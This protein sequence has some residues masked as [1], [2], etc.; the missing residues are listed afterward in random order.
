MK[1][2]RKL[3]LTAALA[4]LALAIAPA[5]AAR[6]T[7]LDEEIPARGIFSL[8]PA[9]RWEEGLLIGNGKMGGVVIGKPND[10]TIHLTHERVVVPEH[11]GEPP[12]KMAHILP[13]LRRMIRTGEGN[14]EKLMWETSR[15]ITGSGGMAWTDPFVN[16]GN[17][18]VEL[19]DGCEAKRYRRSLDYKTGMARVQWG[20]DDTKYEER[21][22]ISRADNVMV[23]Q[24][25]ATGK[26]PLTGRIR[27]SPGYF[28]GGDGASIV[29][30]DGWLTLRYNYGLTDGGYEIVGRVET[31]G[32]S[33]GNDDAIN[34]IDAK[35]V[36][37]LLRVVPLEN[38]GKSQ[39]DS[40]KKE[41]EKIAGSSF[42]QLAKRNIAKHGELFRRVELD[43]GGDPDERAMP[44]EELWAATHA[45]E[46][47]PA[48]L[49]RVFDAGRYEVICSTGDWPPNL[50]GVWHGGGKS[51]WQSDFTFNGNVPSAVA[52]YFNGNMPE[53]ML[54]LT[55]YMEERRPHFRANAEN[56]YDC[57]GLMVPG[58]LHIDGYAQHYSARYP[59]Q[60]WVSGAP[61][62][63]TFFY[64]YYRY[65]GDRDYLK[66][67]VVPWLKETAL[68]FEDYMVEN[69][70]GKYDIIPGY[71]PEHGGMAMNTT[72]DVA[73]V[74]ITLRNLISACRELGIEKDNIPKWQAMLDKMPDYRINKNGQLAEWID[75]RMRDNLGHRH[76]S[77]F[78]P[79]WHGV[80]PDI[81]QDPKL[82]AA[83]RK[84]VADKGE[85]RCNMK[86]GTMGFGITQIGLAA[87]S[88]GDAETVWRT[89]KNLA[90]FFYYPTFASAHN[91]RGNGPAIFN[92][93]ISGSLPAT[94]IEMLLQSDIASITL[95]PALP[96]ELP[97]GT[98]SGALVRGAIT[99]EKLSWN[100]EEVTVVLRSPR[101]QTVTVT[102]GEQNKKVKLEKGKSM[103]LAFER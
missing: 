7:Q 13:E 57:R 52:H 96:E 93:D 74:K 29:A 84:A 55:R 58:R 49:E 78:L 67:H 18:E 50:Q 86:G 66:E 33:S 95:L 81:A 47:T 56:L 25:N 73:G 100:P 30:A 22:F 76:A 92:A 80:Q 89:I 94:M 102:S 61:W 32:K 68:F 5:D 103:T 34:F 83:A 17:I 10:D 85:R 65:T 91:G 88:L 70:N 53:L 11:I 14:P 72:M 31:D 39:I 51:P 8:R 90:A 79:L 63:G 45:K 99:V 46:A 3:I 28:K 62:M 97:S 36:R 27:L 20:D 82:L 59:H 4:V 38:F 44:A 40:T 19:E 15:E 1:T 35:Q 54:S 48:L 43:L 6:N 77:H 42:A 64:D 87:A 2:T 75:P 12:P 37:L 26:K 60:A 23:F 98:L 71:S 69:E 16:A 24:L 41:L 101:T 21:A 9:P